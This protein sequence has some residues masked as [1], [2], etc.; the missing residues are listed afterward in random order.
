MPSR[1]QL[2]G[3]AHSIAECFGKPHW[4]ARYL[5]ESPTK[6]SVDRYVLDEDATCIVCGKRATN[7]HH[8]PPKGIM[9]IFPL[10]TERGLWLLRPALLAVCGSGTTG[11]HGA[12]HSGYLKIEWAWDHEGF[13]DAWWEG[14]LLDATT[15]SSPDLYECGFWRIS[16]DG[17]VIREVRACS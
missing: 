9:R 4:Q 3:L 2:H 11:C 15:P 7:A 13:E 1:D 14:S 10:G 12:I 5:S 8:C 16:R 6:P 17:K